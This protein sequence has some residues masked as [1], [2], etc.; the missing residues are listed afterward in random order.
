MSKF[1]TFEGIE[2]SGKTG[3]MINVGRELAKRGIECL[4]TR[5]PGGTEIGD[6][7][8]EILLN[9]AFTMMAPDVELMLYLASRRQHIEEVIKP[10]LAAGKT[11]LC[12]RYED[13]SLAYQGHA[14]GI[15]IEKVRRMSRAVG[16]ELI[17]E[18]TILLDLPPEVGLERARGRPLEGDTRFEN[19]RLEFHKLVREGY[20]L[21]A[22][23]EPDRFKVIDSH[24]ELEAVNEDVL[25]LVLQKLGID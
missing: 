25:A 10:A 9:P 8:R 5:E 2:G 7:I 6:S 14:R 16:I 19:E 24:R 23:Q 1:I 11:V 21:L 12:D 15:G 20:L 22:N 3:L 17:P 4:N 13:S 18:L